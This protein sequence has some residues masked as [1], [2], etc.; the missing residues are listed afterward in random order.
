MKLPTPSRSF[1]QTAPLAG[2]VPLKGIAAL[3]VGT[4]VDARRGTL[5]LQTAVDGRSVADPRRRLGQARLSAAIFQIRQARARRAASRGRRIATRLLLISPPGAGIACRRN[6][7]AKGVVSTL[8]ATAKG[9]FRVS[10]GASFAQSQNAVWRT[11]DRCDGTTTQVRRGSVRLYDK[12]LRRTVTVRAGKAYLA[13]AHLF[14]A[15][16]GRRPA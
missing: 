9:F 8:T 14:Q 13:R 12:G 3:P 5:S 2:F 4:I 10:G 16:K 7:R 1:R 6:P 15:R 11:I